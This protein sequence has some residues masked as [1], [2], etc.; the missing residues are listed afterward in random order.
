MRRLES[1]MLLQPLKPTFI[2]RFVL[3]CDPVSVAYVVKLEECHCFC[4][5]CLKQQAVDVSKKI[6][7]CSAK[8]YKL[9]EH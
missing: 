5:F 9:V 2:C 6:K 4:C 3:V 8:N 7:C 1:C